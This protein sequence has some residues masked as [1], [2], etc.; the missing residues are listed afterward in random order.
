MAGAP[1]TAR[2]SSSLSFQLSPKQSASRRSVF[3]LVRGAPSKVGLF[4]LLLYHSVGYS[5]KNAGMLMADPIPTFTHVVRALR[6][7]PRLAYL[8]VVEP[9]VE[10]TVTVEASAHNAGHSND[11]I[12]ELWG[13]GGRRLISTGG[14][15]RASALE[16]AEHGEIIAFGRPFLANVRVHSGSIVR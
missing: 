3:E 8:H 11:F 1:R 13:G 10:G 12:R 5:L 16:R 4:P 2:A 14:Y 9:R 7:F 15:T 6:E